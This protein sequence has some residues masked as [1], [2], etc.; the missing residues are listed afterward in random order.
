MSTN[1]EHHSDSA[2][3]M[4]KL[5]TPD[6]AALYLINSIDYTRLQSQKPDLGHVSDKKD[7][8]TFILAIRAGKLEW[9]SENS[10]E[11]NAD[12]QVL[13]GFALL[14]A[15]VHTGITIKVTICRT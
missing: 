3:F 7:L 12:D 8:D 6:M 5:V 15:C 2:K 14:E 4:E 1:N 11:M 13:S 10:I 9:N